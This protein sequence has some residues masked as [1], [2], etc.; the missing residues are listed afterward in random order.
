ML[1]NNGLPEE[2]RE[3]NIDDAERLLACIH[4]LPA[5]LLETLKT[6]NSILEANDLTVTEEDTK[7]CIEFCEDNFSD[8]Y[9]EIENKLK[10]RIKENS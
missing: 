5:K 9:F 7:K 2:V 4:M 3:K 6:L 10:L 1:K 8:L